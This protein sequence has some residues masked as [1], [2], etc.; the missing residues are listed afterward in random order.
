V[1]AFPSLGVGLGYR[2]PIRREILQHVRE[3]GFIEVVSDS[4]FRNEQALRALSTLLPCIPHSLNLSVGAGS[5][6][7]YLERVARIVEIASPPW[8]TDHLAFTKAG[9]ITIGHLAPVPHTEES[10]ARVVENVKKVQAR[11]GVP[12]GLENITTPFYWPESTIEEHDFIREVTRQTGCHLL[13][14]LENVRVNAANHERSARDFLDKLPLERVVQVHV[15]GGMHGEGLEHDTHSAPV[16]EETWR[17]L[18]YLCDVR[19]PP[20]VLLERDG[21][22][23]PFADLLAELRRARG[24]LT[25]G[26]RHAA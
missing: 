13:L 26:A 10:L 14:D 17:L 5:V 9:G 12:F 23:P 18:A 22:F 19:P 1:D 2:S 15:A 21:A 7:A 25:G 3:L 8:F 20:G 6:N 11:I 4:F 24:I 16:S